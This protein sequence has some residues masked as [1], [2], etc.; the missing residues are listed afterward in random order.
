V[1]VVYCTAASLPRLSAGDAAW[2]LSRVG[3]LAGRVSTRPCREIQLD[4]DWNAST[5]DGWFDFVAA[6]DAACRADGVEVTVTLRLNQVRDRA[7]MGVP[8]VQ[9]ASLMLYGMGDPGDFS[10][11]WNGV[12]DPA[13]AAAYLEPWLASY[14]LDLDFAF[15]QYVQLRVFNPWRRLQ[16]MVRLAD[17]S[18]LPAGE[19]RGRVLEAAADGWIAGA[20]V[21][22]G[23]L[24]VVDQASP[25]GAARIR[26]LIAG[27]YRGASPRLLLFDADPESLRSQNA[28]E[29][30]SRLLD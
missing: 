6:V 30:R 4:G 19:R 22:A 8:P 27:L 11:P 1:A 23:D 26:R 17:E 9:R 13:L 2:L 10:L 14:P 21:M 3:E 7:A 25:E 12:M 16:A 18:A 28:H 24:L 15:P 20:R 29:I 5:R